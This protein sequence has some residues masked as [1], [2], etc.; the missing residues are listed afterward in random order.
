MI[1]F[2]IYKLICSEINLYHII[3]RC[4]NFRENK[5]SRIKGNQKTI[6]FSLYSL[7]PAAHIIEH[8]R[9]SFNTSGKKYIKMPFLCKLLFYFSI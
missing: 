5:N 9:G 4:Q 8:I 3:K 2:Y 6:F 1:I 7:P